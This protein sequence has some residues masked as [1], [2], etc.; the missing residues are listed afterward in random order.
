M[1]KFLNFEE[2]NTIL[3]AI[4]TSTDYIVNGRSKKK[5]FYNTLFNKLFTITEDDLLKKEE[6]NH[7][8]S[9]KKSWDIAIKKANS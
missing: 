7:P 6:I 2:Y 1:K 4:D 3:L 9:E 5:E 8:I